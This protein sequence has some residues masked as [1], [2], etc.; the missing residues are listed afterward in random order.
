MRALVTGGA[1]FIGSNLALELEKLGSEVT[2]VD[3]FSTGN[4]K[5]LGGFKGEIIK[6]DISQPINIQGDFDN[7]FHMGCI[8]SATV[9]KDDKILKEN[10][11]GFLE[12]LKFSIR[13]NANLILGSSSA[14]YG[15]GYVPMRENQKL[16]PLNAYGLSKTVIDHIAKKKFDKINIVCLRYFNVY[17]N[18]E[19]YKGKLASMVY[20]LTKTIKEDKKPRIFK[21]G[22]QKRDYIYIK[23]VVDAN[24]KAASLNKSGIFNVGS[25]KQ[26]TFNS[27]IKL[28]CKILDKDIKIE[29]IDNPYEKIYQDNTLSYNLNTER[30]LKFKPKYDLESGI[31][32]YLKDI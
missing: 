26:I 6:K 19:I 25:G 32:D 8:T 12:V 10:I 14:V 18:K 24:I 28:I 31:R 5:N 7:I 21:Y 20:Q 27:L 23:D 13:K 22:E 17:G 3:N 4:I 1:G 2:V 15:N 16:K 9:E 11:N 29:Y 30:I